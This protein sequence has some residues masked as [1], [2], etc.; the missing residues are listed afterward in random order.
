MSDPATSVLHKHDGNTVSI[1]ENEAYA[2]VSTDLGEGRSLVVNYYSFRHGMR[3]SGFRLQSWNFEGSK[4]GSDWT[5]LRVHKNDNSLPKRAFSEAAWEV[6]DVK[7]AYRHFRVR[8]TANNSS[9]NGGL[10]CVGIELWG[11]LMEHGEDEDEE[12]EEVG[13]R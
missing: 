3:N 9:Q 5:V 13:F 7:Q 10:C 11:I 2:W 4:D 8:M 12:E 1:T 6:E